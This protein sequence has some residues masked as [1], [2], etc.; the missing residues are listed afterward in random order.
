MR[1]LDHKD[2]IKNDFV[3]VAGD[4]V[5]NMK[6]KPALDAHKARRNA[7]KTSI[8]TMV[9]RSGMSDAHR[10]RLGDTAMTLVLDPSTHRLVKVEEYDSSRSMQSRRRPLRLDCHLFGERDELQVRTDMLDANIYICAP[11]VLMLF[12]DNFDYQVRSSFV[13]LNRD[14]QGFRSTLG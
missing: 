12:S 10:R 8:M 13:E 14:K 5:T 7:D 4:V 2:V 11:E 9:M 6:L 3:L 1:L